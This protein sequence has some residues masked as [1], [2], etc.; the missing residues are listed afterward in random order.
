MRAALWIIAAG[1]VV[2]GLYWFRDVLTQFALGVFLWLSIEAVARG[3]RR[4]L[5]GLP[6]WAGLVGAVLVVLAALAAIVALVAYNTRAFAATA[7]DYGARIDALLA[8][9]HDMLNLGGVAPELRDLTATIDPAQLAARMAGIAQGLVGDAVFILIYAAF[10]LAGTR[11]FAGKMRAIFP[12]PGDRENARALIGSI[13]DALEQYVWVQT[14]CS[15]IISVATWG[16]LTALGLEHA[17]F[18]SF[19]IFFL[20]YIPTVGSLVAVALPT[21]FAAVQFDNPLMV[22]AVAAGVGVWQFAIGNFVQPRMTGLSL[23]LSTVTVLLA[24][25]LWGSLWGAVGMFL[26]APLAVA[27]MVVLAQ[28]P[29]TRWIAILMSDDGHPAERARRGRVA[30]APPA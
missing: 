23:N 25:S 13:R 3:L 27:L 28:F 5:P 16:T 10:L 15:T 14:V 17:L 21:A 2:A 4:V 7:G 26:A 1:V 9:V 30:P 6:R 20:N 29:D 22:A 24:L 11:T 8:R 12:G 18:W 19:I